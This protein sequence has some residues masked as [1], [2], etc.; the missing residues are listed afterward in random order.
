MKVIVANP[1]WPGEGYGTRSNVRWPHRRGDKV[2]TFPIYLAYTVS[3]LKSKGFEARGVDAV[4]KEWGITAF[5]AEMK[6]AKPGVIILEVST[7]SIMFDLETAHIL[8]KETG[9]FIAFAGP[10]ATYFHKDIIENYNFVD[11]CIRGE[12]E[13]TALGLCESLRDSKPLSGVIGLTYRK[14]AKA[15][16]NPDRPFRK[17]LDS[18]PYPDREDFPI[19]SYQQAFFGGKKTALMISSRGCPY[20][21]TYCLW[22]RTV[23]GKAFRTRSA[24]GVADEIEMMVK[25]YGVDEIYF[26]DE[27]F[28][29]N[30]A[31]VKDICDELAKRKI[32]IPWLCMGRVDNVTAEML[33]AMKRAGC[34]EIFFGLESGSE[35]LLGEMKKGITK[36]QMR[37]AV[38]LTQKAGIVA[39]GSFILGLPGE[40]DKSVRETL[41]FARSLGANYVQFAVATPF[42]GSELFEEVASKGLLEIDS[43][44]DLDQTKGAVI[45]TKHLSKKELEGMLKWAYRSYYTSPKVIWNNVRSVRSL[46][47]VRKL[48]RGVRSVL[49]RITFYEK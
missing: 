35:R 46:S 30:E 16:A 14:A 32:N 27:T 12:M 2:L 43:W 37:M 38:K 24:A 8:K 40:D 7:P 26:D 22:P 39:G 17:D 15:C 33:S 25:K 41:S 31:R 47:D 36:E 3:M 28:T 44:A 11:A 42:P 1:P 4:E 49:A 5:A 9:A 13:E 23:T 29:I 10:H 20:M 21:C 34:R 19:E 6:K 45:R 48:A 18:M